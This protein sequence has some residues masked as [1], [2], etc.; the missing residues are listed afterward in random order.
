MFQLSAI[1]TQVNSMSTSEEEQNSDKC[2]QTA[3]WIVCWSFS[4]F[5]DNKNWCFDSGS[6]FHMN[7]RNDWMRNKS[8]K[9]ISEILVTN[10]SKMSVESVGSVLVDVDRAG[11]YCTIPVNGVLHV[12]D[13]SINL[14]SVSQI[15]Q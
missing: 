2:Q 3:K 9:P 11:D 4:G 6:S 12:P 14:L 13:L 5:I 1:W 8:V 10:N 7:M 15:V